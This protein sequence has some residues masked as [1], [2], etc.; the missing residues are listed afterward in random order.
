[1]VDLIGLVNTLSA[2]IEPNKSFPSPVAVFSKIPKAISRGNNINTASTLKKSW[3]VA[4]ANA[5]LNSFPRFICP[6]ETMMLVTVV[7]IFAP[8][9]IGIALLRGK[10]IMPVL[11]V[12]LAIPTMIDVVVEE[13]WNMVVAKIPMNK[14]TKG[15]LVVVIISLA[16]SPPICFIPKESP[17]IPTRKR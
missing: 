2:L 6:M 10:K 12:A 8:M 16:K 17:L 1:M 3:T 9:I 15:S 7:P 14:A 4:A 5:R 13:L 11:V